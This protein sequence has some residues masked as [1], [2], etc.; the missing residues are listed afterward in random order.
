MWGRKEHEKDV[1]LETTH[2]P[3]I[4]HFSKEM[5]RLISTIILHIIIIMCCLLP[6]VI[7]ERFDSLV[8]L[9]L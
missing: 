9:T 1:I 6:H 7:P 8:W 2:S 5:Y 4:S 3:L